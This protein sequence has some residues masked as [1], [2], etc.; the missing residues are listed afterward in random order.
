[1]ICDNFFISI[2][3]SSLNKVKEINGCGNKGV[4][5][6]KKGSAD[7]S[8]VVTLRRNYVKKE[9]QRHIKKRTEGKSYEQDSPKFMRLIEKL[10]INK[11]E[12]GYIMD[13]IEGTDYINDQQ[14]ESTLNKTQRFNFKKLNINLDNVE[15]RRREFRIK[16]KLND[17][18]GNINC[19]R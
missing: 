14:D 18:K 4:V 11:I 12:S 7:S 8:K 16:T 19:K 2:S 10:G 15:D 13:F 3:G 9:L 17:P 6:Y 5:R 1:M